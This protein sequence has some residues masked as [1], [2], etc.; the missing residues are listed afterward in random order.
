MNVFFLRN[1]DKD[2]NIEL[3]AVYNIVLE[4]TIFFRVQELYLISKCVFL[5][6]IS[7]SLLAELLRAKI[8]L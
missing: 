3:R 4:N 1:N 7:F 8:I 2:N 5:F 6:L